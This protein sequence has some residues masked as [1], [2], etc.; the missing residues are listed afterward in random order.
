[1]ES[2]DHLSPEGVGNDV[3]YVELENQIFKQNR[4]DYKYVAPNDTTL[5]QDRSSI[6]R[7]GRHRGLFPNKCCAL[8]AALKIRGMILWA[9][10]PG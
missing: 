10:I 4:R 6:G 3:K 9:V 7:G 5:G 2:G 1:L 8:R